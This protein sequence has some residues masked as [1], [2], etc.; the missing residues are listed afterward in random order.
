MEKTA[1]ESLWNSCQPSD[2]GIST[3]VFRQYF[4]PSEL[5]NNQSNY[6]FFKHHNL[7]D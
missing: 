7:K 4:A 2:N 6:Y 3:E 5:E 1:R